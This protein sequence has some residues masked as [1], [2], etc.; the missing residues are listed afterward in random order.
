MVTL[1]DV[2]QRAGVSTATVSRVLNNKPSAIA[3]T[4]RTRRRVEQAVKELGYRPNLAARGLKRGQVTPSVGFLNCMGYELSSH[5]VFAPILEGIQDT[6]AKRGSSLIYTSYDP[7]AVQPLLD[8]LDSVWNGL[9]TIGLIGESLAQILEG[10]RHPVIG[11]EPY[12]IVSSLTAYYLDYEQSMQAVANHLK[13]LGHRRVAFLLPL[14]DAPY[15][16]G[17]EYPPFIE[18]REAFEIAA[19][20]CGIHVTR[21]AVERRHDESEVST[22]RKMWRDRRLDVTAVVAA[23]D[24]MA[25]GVV[26]GAQDLG[27]RVP[28]DISVVGFDDVD[29]AEDMSPPLTT[30]RINGFELGKAVVER[31]FEQIEGKGRSKAA[32][33]RRGDESVIRM[34][35]HF[36]VRG[37]T[38]PAPIR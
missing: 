5:P 29:L 13:E 8:S 22:G 19:R 28:E 15:H 23:N 1:R 30:V 16:P 37:S 36:L 35:T 38:G 3:V 33:L 27:M 26:Q 32:N 10:Y 11:I 20:A 18:R 9:I 17:G 14:V 12:R 24:R 7:Q 6:A 31:L 25:F 4:E 34:P 2:A 21:I